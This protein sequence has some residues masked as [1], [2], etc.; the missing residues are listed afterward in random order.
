M[1]GDED[2]QNT[3]DESKSLA[4][5]QKQEQ[6]RLIHEEAKMIAAANDAVHQR[7]PS[8]IDSSAQV[9][10]AIYGVDIPGPDASPKDKIRYCQIMVGRIPSLSVNE[11]WEVR[12]T[13]ID[14][15]DQSRS[16]GREDIVDERLDA[17][18]FR[19]N[20]LIAI[21]D[22]KATQGLTGVGALITQDRRETLNQ[23]IRQQP[24]S[25]NSPGIIEGLRKIVSG[26]G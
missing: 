8:I 7:N 19:I 1:F 23:T 9:R 11:G 22:P 20:E 13:F 5:R 4:E 3:E 10:I 17:L 26:R 14:I 15:L 16:Q 2:Q 21:A 6:I 24:L 18:I 12:R 25:A